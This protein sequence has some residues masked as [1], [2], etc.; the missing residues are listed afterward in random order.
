MKRPVALQRAPR[1]QPERVHASLGLRRVASEPERSE[2]AGLTLLQ[3]AREQTALVG[4]MAQ[5][6]P[7]APAPA[8]SSDCPVR[9]VGNVV[10]TP[11]PDMERPDGG[12][13]R[14]SR[15]WFR[16]RC[17]CGSY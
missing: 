11:P 16:L 7:A 8:D 15:L 12:T 5:R 17:R 3:N 13:H 14:A 10:L 6:E 1:A 4:R 9:P 2:Q